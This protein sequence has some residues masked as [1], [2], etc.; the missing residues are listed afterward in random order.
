M[1]FFRSSYNEALGMT[2]DEAVKMSPMG[3]TD[4]ISKNNFTNVKHFV[5]PGEHD[6]PA[7]R[8]QSQDYAKAVMKK[9]GAFKQAFIIWLFSAGKIRNQGCEVD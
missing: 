8:Q 1:Q 9:S 7:F 5:V 3:F 2:L 6:S 4:R